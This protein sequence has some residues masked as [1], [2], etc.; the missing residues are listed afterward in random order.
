[1]AIKE[2]S[3]SCE[4]TR[5]HESDVYAK[6]KLPVYLYT[7]VLLV[8]VYLKILDSAAVVRIRPR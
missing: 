6:R 7:S 1:M 4:S 5:H 3:F 8:D 2:Y